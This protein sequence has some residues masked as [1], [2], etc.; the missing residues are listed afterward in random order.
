MSSHSHATDTVNDSRSRSLPSYFKKPELEG[1]FTQRTSVSNPRVAS[2]GMV[3]HDL[4]ELTPSRRSSA[5]ASIEEDEVSNF[6]MEQTTNPPTT[7][8][9]TQ[10]PRET[11]GTPGDLGKVATLGTAGTMKTSGITCRLWDTKE[12][13]TFFSGSE[14]NREASYQWM[15]RYEQLSRLS[16][17][18]EQEKI[19]WFPSYLSKTVRAWFNQLQP[20][21]KQSWKDIK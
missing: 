2:R 15:R 3:Y 14:Y 21:Y 12:L 11:Q 8:L 18:T 16:G 7:S 1:S 19:A 9:V 20:H 6:K 5:Q 17:W 10:I 4:A 13:C